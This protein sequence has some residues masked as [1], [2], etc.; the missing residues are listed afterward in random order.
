VREIAVDHDSGPIDTISGL[1]NSSAIRHTLVP[2]RTKLPSQSREDDEG[3]DDNP[4]SRR[5]SNLSETSPHKLR[6]FYIS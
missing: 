4:S 3:C 6:P 2:M 5:R 1:E